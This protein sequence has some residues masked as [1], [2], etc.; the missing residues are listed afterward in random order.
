MRIT[1]HDPNNPIDVSAVTASPTGEASAPSV[2]TTV[3][4]ELLLRL[5]TWD[6]SKTL[7]AVP[8]GHTETYHVD[9][10]GHDNWGGYKTQATAGST[11]IAQ[12]D[13]S[14]GA[15]YVGFTVAIKPASQGGG[16][17]TPMKLTLGRDTLGRVNTQ[18]Y[19]LGNGSAGPSDTVTRSQSG[20][21]TSG[22][23]NGQTKTYN[24]DKADRLTSATI[25]SN[26][27]NYSFATPSSCTGTYNANK[28]SNRTSQTINGQTT[29]Y[30]YDQADRLISS[31]DPALTNAQYDSHGNTT[32]LGSSPVTTFTYDSS[33][34]NIGITE[35][36]KSI[37]YTRDVQ[38]RIITRTLVNGTT[39]TNKYT[40]TASGDTPDLLLDNS[41]NVVEKYLSL[42]GGALLTIRPA[43][44][45]NNQKIYSLPNIHGDTMAM[46]DATGTLSG[47]FQY[48][49]FGNKISSTLPNNT[50]TGA[51]YGWV[52]KHQKDT[53]TSFTLAPTEM[54]ARVYLSTLGRFIQVDPVEGGVENSYVYPTDPINEFD[55]N[56]QWNFRNWRKKQDRKT[57]Q[58]KKAALTKKNTSPQT[59]AW[60]SSYRKSNVKTR[61]VIRAVT[62]FSWVGAASSASDYYHAGTI[63][64]AGGGCVVGAALTPEAAGGG[65]I[66][67]AP[68]GAGILGAA[69]AGWGFIEGGL[70][71]RGADRFN[72]GAPD[73]PNGL[74]YLK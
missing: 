38:G 33:D 2:T 13:L 11:G 3:G 70:K 68:I 29:T 10:S 27:Y 8:P 16:S 23:E 40:F 73:M 32:S 48:D 60:Q 42:P 17:Q 66:V 34:R 20:Q 46:T 58:R 9:V 18:S 69:F 50:A 47:T 14:G 7:V 54:G 36:T 5:A 31:S 22:T 57:V 45:G 59:K 30:C 72:T 65:C 12:L 43:Q 25:G 67:I 56:G 44:S 6:Q 53:E 39:T 4:N 71:L 26:T 63:L 74:E 49:P 19:T 21:I 41:N 64:G 1:G 62:K 51:T 35:G 37:A 28:N 55:L 61:A 24:Y 52:G 15:P